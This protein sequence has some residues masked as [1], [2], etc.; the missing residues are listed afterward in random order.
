MKFNIKYLVTKKLII[1]DHIW[2]LAKCCSMRHI[3]FFTEFLN[4]FKLADNY[5]K[6][7]T[8]FADF[9]PL[10]ICIY[11]RQWRQHKSGE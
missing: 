3:C 5:C 1:N 4:N 11:A 2:R 9:A 7:F 8:L 10:L 6:K